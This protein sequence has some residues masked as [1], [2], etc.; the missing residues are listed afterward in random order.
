MLWHLLIHLLENI[1]CLVR[2]EMVHN[3][4]LLNWIYVNEY[5]YYCA[6]CGGNLQQTIY[7]YCSA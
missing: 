1:Y 2:K 5:T 7:Q 3:N 4:N 6:R